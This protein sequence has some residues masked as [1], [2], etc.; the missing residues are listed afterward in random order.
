MHEKRLLQVVFNTKGAITS[1]EGEEPEAV[2]A[3]GGGARE[4]KAALAEA[5]EW[6]GVGQGSGR[7]GS[8]DELTEGVTEGS[9]E[10]SSRYARTDRIVPDS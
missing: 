7:K 8:N 1:H 4:L 3:I 10:Y 9:A 5:A 2:H 6:H